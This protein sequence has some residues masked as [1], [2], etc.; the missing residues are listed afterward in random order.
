MRVEA[1]RQAREIR[2]LFLL[3]DE[4][5][6]CAGFFFQTQSETVRGNCNV[7]KFRHSAVHLKLQS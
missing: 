5:S 4:N 7:I 6:V 3:R 2:V 1:R